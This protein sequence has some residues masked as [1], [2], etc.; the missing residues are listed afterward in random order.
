MDLSSPAI[1]LFIIL[2]GVYEYRRRE[3]AQSATIEKI[4]SGTT[5][6][7]QEPKPIFW[8]LLTTASVCGL[9]AL[10]DGALLYAGIHSRGKSALDLE[11]MACMM[12]VPLLL[13]VLIFVRDMRRY[14][15][16]DHDGR[17]S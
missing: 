10:F 9:L 17:G 11:I 14:A 4:R 12:S 3:K 16:S 1:S 6:A 7:P 5:I 2:Y 15:L 8:K 13:L